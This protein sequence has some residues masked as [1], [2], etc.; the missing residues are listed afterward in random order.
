MQFY[1]KILFSCTVLPPNITGITITPSPSNNNNILLQFNDTVSLT[2]AAKGGPRIVIRWK[3]NDGSTINTVANDTGSVTYEVPSLSTV[4]AGDYYCEAIIDEMSVTSIN[5][6][7][8]DK[9]LFASTYMH[10]YMLTY[11]CTHAYTHILM[12]THMH[13]H[14]YIYIIAFST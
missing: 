12:Y 7:L 14:T 9:C 5:Y 2:C 13:A 6:T 11:M 8:Y 10:M 1:A 3:F 4:H